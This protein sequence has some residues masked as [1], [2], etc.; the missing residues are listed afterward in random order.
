MSDVEARRACDQAQR[1]TGLPATD[2]V[3]FEPGPLVNAIADERERYLRKRK[4]L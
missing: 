4:A 3:R 2:P 1:E